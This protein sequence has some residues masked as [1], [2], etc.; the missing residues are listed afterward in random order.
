MEGVYLIHLCEDVLITILIKLRKKEHELIR[1]DFFN[2]NLLQLIHH[3]VF[4]GVHLKNK[5]TRYFLLRI[6]LMDLQL[7]SPIT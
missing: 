4:V 5:K 6:K 7:P 1:D 2:I 3:T